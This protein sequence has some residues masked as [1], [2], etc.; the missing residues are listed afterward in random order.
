MESNVNQLQQ[1]NEEI[2][3]NADDL[4]TSVARLGTLTKFLRNNTDRQIANTTK[5]LLL[6]QLDQLCIMLIKR[7]E[8][9]S[10]SMGRS[11]IKD[12]DVQKAFEEL[13][14][15]HVFI[16]QITN[17]LDQQKDELSELAS[18]QSL[19]RFLEE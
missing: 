12:E 10:T 18:R 1:A 8:Q 14:Q 17:L 6:E 15:P 3:T 9:H 2:E 4:G 13:L 5:L 16:D 11:K 19:I 7:A